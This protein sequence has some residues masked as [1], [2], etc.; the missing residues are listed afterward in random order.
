MTINDVKTYIYFVWKLENTFLRIYILVFDCDNNRHEFL[1]I[2]STYRTLLLQ[3]TQGVSVGQYCTF[4]YY[5][6]GRVA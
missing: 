1:D 3:S 5:L 6:V 2:T 4:Y